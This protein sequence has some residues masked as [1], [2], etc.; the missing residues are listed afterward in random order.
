MWN[1]HFQFSIHKLYY[2][3]RLKISVKG[4]YRRLLKYKGKVKEKVG[5]KKISNIFQREILCKI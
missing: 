5:G 2:T 4:K 3:S 1:W